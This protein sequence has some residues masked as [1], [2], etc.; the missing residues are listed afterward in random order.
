V[1][2]LEIALLVFI[3]LVVIGSGMGFY[4]HNKKEEK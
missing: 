3:V 4:I 1:G 2:I